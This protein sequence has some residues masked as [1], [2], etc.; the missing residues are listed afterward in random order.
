ME[1]S[2]KNVIRKLRKQ[3]EPGRAMKIK[4]ADLCLKYPEKIIVTGECNCIHPQK[5]NHHPNYDFPF[6]VEKLCPT[7]HTEKHLHK[8][9][10]QDSESITD[11][12]CR[13]KDQDK[14]LMLFASVLQFANQKSKDQVEG[15]LNSLTNTAIRGSDLSI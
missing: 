3:Y 2:I 7:C 5:H 10:L 8:N 14:R 12:I 9:N 15:L 13:E 1:N 4:A 6:S 11:L